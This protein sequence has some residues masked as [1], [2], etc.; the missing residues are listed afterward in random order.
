MR[1]GTWKS[2]K[3]P[4][5]PAGP[6][7][8]S[9]F[10]VHVRG[11]WA[12][13]E[14]GSRVQ[15]SATAPVAEPME[16]PAPVQRIGDARCAANLPSEAGGPHRTAVASG[17]PASRRAAVRLQHCPASDRS[18]WEG[19]REQEVKMSTDQHGADR[20]AA[21]YASTSTGIM[22]STNDRLDVT[23]NYAAQAGLEI[24]AQYVDLHGEKT[25]LLCMIEDAAAPDPTFRKVLAASPSR[26][27]RR[28]DELERHRTRLAVHRV[29]IILASE[30]APRSLAPSVADY[31]SRAHSEQ[32]RHPVRVLRVGRRALRLPEGSRRGPRRPPPSRGATRCYATNTVPGGTGRI[33]NH[34]HRRVAIRS[35]AL[36]C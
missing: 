27:S 26:I 31:F 36:V 34:C 14:E 25:Q 33:W 24:V 28:V 18:E 5:Q 11:R 30:P 10:S 8:P 32:V 19:R 4:S 13:F 1:A 29:E 3:L 7:G 35:A 2:S 16:R 9:Q 12:R 15:P 23:R 21:I 17:G 20:R 6:N 22:E